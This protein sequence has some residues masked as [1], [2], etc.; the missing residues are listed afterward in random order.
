[1]QLPPSAD[2][3]RG[4]TPHRRTGGQSRVRHKRREADL[5]G[6]TAGQ[7]GL[8]MASPTGFEPVLPP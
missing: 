3:I 4:L 1:M 2:Q 5:T 6:F 7:V 8:E